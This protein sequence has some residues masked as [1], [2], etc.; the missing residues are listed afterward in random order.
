ML[1][2]ETN[3]IYCET[4]MKH[5]NT[6]CGQNAEF[7]YVKSGGTYSNNRALKGE[8]LFLA[9][10]FDSSVGIAIG[11]GLDGR[12]SVPGRSKIF[13]VSTASRPAMGPT[14]SDIERVPA[15]PSPEVK[16]PGR[17][18]DHSLLFW[19]RCQERRNYERESVNRS[20]LDL[21]RKTRDICRYILRQHW[22]TCLIALPVR[23]NLKQRSLLTVVSATSALPFQPRRHQ[24]NVF[25]PVVNR[26]TRQT[27]PIIKR[28]HFF[29]NVFCVESFCPQETHKR[30]LLL[31]SALL[32]HGLHFD[33]WNQPLNMCVRV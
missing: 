5:K 14:Q 18:D 12:N 31:G 22:C 1:F 24:R 8:A 16:R 21:K 6:S 33:Y 29:M 9:Y 23:R 25:H 32:K 3:A 26:F 2:R 4:H 20:Q 28:K 15:S 13:L 11:Y 27:L 10:Y 30:T 19:C 7:Y 17:E